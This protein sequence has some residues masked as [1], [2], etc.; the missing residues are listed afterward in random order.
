MTASQTIQQIEDAASWDDRVQKVR[1]VP[2]RHGTD[3]HATI[4]AEVAQRV[5]VPHLAPD[6]AY[7]HESQFD[8]IMSGTLF[9]E[10]AG[11]LR[12]KQRKPDTMQG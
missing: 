6:F 3:E 8:R 1:Q 4:Y 5:Y 10:P 11:D 7:I 12:K 2:Q 9:G